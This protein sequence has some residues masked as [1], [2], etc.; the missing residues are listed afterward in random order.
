MWLIVIKILLQCKKNKSLFVF[1]YF[2]L[3]V[4]R[5]NY[6]R[7]Y[8][9]LHRAQIE[10]CSWP[11]SEE[12]RY[13]VSRYIPQYPCISCWTV[14]AEENQGRLRECCLV[15]GFMCALSSN[16]I[17]SFKPFKVYGYIIY[18][19]QTVSDVRLWE[20]RQ[21]SIPVLDRSSPPCQWLQWKASLKYFC[22][23]YQQS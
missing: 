8:E 15:L 21:S 1:V 9:S 2:F 10:R 13:I 22:H 4:L 16:L 14:K 18:S 12:I 17:H 3:K 5:W 20:N 19:C 23:L 7:F 11:G 6:V